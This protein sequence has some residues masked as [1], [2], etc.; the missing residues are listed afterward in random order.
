MVFGLFKKST[1]PTIEQAAA[2]VSNTEDAISRLYGFPSLTEGRRV[3]I[4]FGVCCSV[5]AIGNSVSSK[6]SE[7]FINFSLDA[8][9]NSSESIKR[10]K[11]SD[12]FYFTNGYSGE[13]IDFDQDEFIRKSSI[14]DS[15]NTWKNGRGI[16]TQL[17][18]THGGEGVRRILERRENIFHASSIFLRNIATGK[19]QGSAEANLRVIET[20]NQSIRD[21]LTNGGR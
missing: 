15:G 6:N 8:I 12:A 14:V 21:F 17:L 11:V 16:L 4:K 2:A 13:I 18:D 19:P 9:S 10:I 1:V 5:I 3:R 7:A 20:L